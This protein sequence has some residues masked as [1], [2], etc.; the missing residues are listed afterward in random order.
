MMSVGGAGRC[1]EIGLDRRVDLG[2]ALLQEP[3]LVGLGPPAALGQEMAHPGDRLGLPALAHLGVVAVAAGIVGGGVVG[4]AIGQRLDQRG[5]AVAAGM[6]QRPL[7]HGPHGDDVVAVDLLAGDARG[8]RLL[9]QRLGGGLRR[10]RHGNRPLVV[11]DDEHHRQPPDPGEVHGLVDVAFGAGAVA[12]DADRHARL[13]PELER[14]RHTDGVGCLR[15]DRHAD[16]KVLARAREARATLVP[17]PV[18][19]RFHERDAAPKLR[20]ELAK[21]RQQHI[22]GPHRG[23]DP[24]HHGLLAERGGERAQPAGA[25]QAHGLGIERPGEDHPPIEP[26]QLGPA[27]G[28]GRKL[29]RERAVR[30]NDL[31][32]GNGEARDRSHRGCLPDRQSI[33]YQ[34]SEWPLGSKS[35][36]SRVNCRSSEY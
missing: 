4:E 5:R 7:E 27:L 32:A 13:V 22:L 18:A 24:D 16:R 6:A 15:S 36:A 9:R 2:R 19:E 26:H 35:S 17:A 28:E 33:K 14:E 21:R 29:A 31:G 34:V 8:H 25:L 1:R 23:T 20:A 30:T 12:E 11:V 3:L 10:A